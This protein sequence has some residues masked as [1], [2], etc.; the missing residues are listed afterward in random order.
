MPQ[1]DARSIQ[2]P[3][4]CQGLFFSGCSFV[5]IA[6]D[7]HCANHPLPRTLR[8]RPQFFLST[9]LLPPTSLDCA[10]SKALITSTICFWL[11]HIRVPLL[12]SLLSVTQ[13]LSTPPTNGTASSPHPNTAVMSNES[14]T[15]VP[16]EAEKVFPFF[17]LPVEPVNRVAHNLAAPWLPFSLGTPR[18]DDEHDYENIDKDLLLA[19]DPYL[20]PHLQLEK[21]CRD[22]EK[23]EEADSDPK[24]WTRMK[25][26][27]EKV[28][29]VVRAS[30]DNEQYMRASGLAPALLGCALSHFSG[31]RSIEYGNYQD[32]FEN[33]NLLQ[34]NWKT[35]KLWE[36]ANVREIADT[37]LASFG[38][39]EDEYDW[40]KYCSD[41]LN[42][43]I[44]A[45]VT[46]KT[47]LPDSDGYYDP[48]EHP[49]VDDALHFLSAAP[50]NL[51]ELEICVEIM[52]AGFDGDAD[53]HM[54]ETA[55]PLC[56]DL[57]SRIHFPRLERLKIKS[58][59]HTVG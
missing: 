51:K 33:P 45:L 22:N 24:E 23:A 39:M 15:P 7:F 14:E 50:H 13:A 32:K 44:T 40:L 3:Y 16:R 20:S 12:G 31:L 54:A 27:F 2:L 8:K 6:E 1:P 10:L 11:K 37:S 53:D 5:L 4:A 38:W 52:P 58:T 59:F 25:Q 56:N 49:R 36:A 21:R 46:S 48:V 28:E 55:A 35:T 17:D 9:H 30:H 18:R 34:F 26:S 57:F 41:G 47:T 19:N 42:T 43:V 29:M